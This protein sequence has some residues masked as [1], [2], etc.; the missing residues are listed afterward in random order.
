MKLFVRKEPRAIALAS[1]DYVLVFERSKNSPKQ[2]QVKNAPPTIMV[3]TMSEAS[4]VNGG[5]FVEWTAFLIKGLLGVI[6]VRNQVFIGLIT[7]VKDVAKPRWRIRDGKMKSIESIFQ[8]L[9]VNFYCLDSPLYDQWLYYVSE[10][11]QE[12]LLTEHPCAPLKKL[13]S[14]GTFYYSR[15]FDI[16]SVLQERGL[17]HRIENTIENQEKKFIWNL[18]LMSEI[19]QLRGR[20]T[21]A[22][23][24]A[25]D[26]GQFL[27]F[28]IRGFCKT[29]FANEIHS[30]TS[31]TLISKTS[32]EDLD[33]ITDF[34]KGID[35]DG[36]VA[37]FIESELIIQTERY[38]FAYVQTSADVP[39]SWEVVEGQ[40]LHSKKLK[41]T[42][43]PERIQATF[44][45]HFDDMI[46]RYGVISIVNLIK[47]RSSSQET[48]SGAYK[49]CAEAKELH[50]TAVDYPIDVIK[51]SPYKLMYFLRDDIY[52][53]GAFAYDI[54]RGVYVGKQT[55]SF[56]V[57]AVEATSKMNLVEMCISREVLDLT[58]DE[59][60]DFAITTS[61]VKKHEALWSDN[62]FWLHRIHMKNIKNPA[63]YKKLY[64]QVFSLSSKVLLYDPLHAHIAK[65]LKKLK[66]EYTYE[67]EITIFAGTFNVN[68][69]QCKDEAMGT[70]L[71]PPAGDS[72]G[73]YADIY[74][75]GLEEV[76]ELTPGHMLSTDPMSKQFWEKT[77]L[78]HLNSQ[79][80]R[81][82][83]CIGTNQLGG[84]LLLLY[85]SE[86]ECSKIKHLEYD[87]KKTGFGGISANKGAA[88]IRFMYSATKFCFIVS[89]LAAG[90]ENV[91]QRHSDYKTIMKSIG[92]SRGKRIKDHDGIIW[93][94][95]FN[96]RILLSNEEVRRAILEGDF[97]KLFEKDQ[98]NQ[99]MIAGES[100]PYFNEMEIKFPPTYKFDPGTKTYDTSEKMRIPAWTDRI[101]SRGEILKAISYGCAED[102]I[103]SDHRPVYAT[104]KARTT[105]VDEEQR[106]QLSRI[107]HERLTEMFSGL[108]D[109]QK[110]AFLVD[111]ELIVDK[112][113]M[114]GK[115]PLVS[116]VK[117]GK[118]LPP[119]SSDLRKWWIGNGKQVRITLD[120][121]PKKQM[122][123]PERPVN[124]FIPGEDGQAY[125]VP[126]GRLNN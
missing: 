84:V 111:S 103:F 67:K 85:V 52:E 91:E 13:F 6:H 88:A 99:Q 89:H 38:L 65:C 16:S 24:Q 55:G 19:L 59:L 10:I 62:D 75:I 102:V 9:S 14:D 56:R 17:K 97:G 118:R 124:P 34:Q 123:N 83:N 45:R 39:L 27:T 48:L 76:V 50:Y 121:D 80:G 94:G 8:I 60:E 30:P 92:F 11:C 109:E 23:L 3:K 42:K 74:V 26:G 68:G 79:E 4:L 37:R 58:T 7:G 105:V 53:F 93:M 20:I 112:I 117:K 96:Y 31:L 108:N 22:E 70:W 25:F 104:F 29:V 36:N 54:A 44:D 101:L 5:G 115:L 64:S 15:D 32:I 86:S 49:A 63:K 122:L 98:L 40:L 114:E 1:N 78:R 69:K 81:H 33:S 47:H 119:P 113:E 72:E 2:P 71:F 73:N 125:V 51:K 28:L 82:Y 43:S 106:G 120:V 66:N 90:L 57:S 126:K 116:Q 61:L 46:S 77:I 107:I 110:Y 41:L 95:D 21:P 87:V 100:F 18:N 35:D 12:K